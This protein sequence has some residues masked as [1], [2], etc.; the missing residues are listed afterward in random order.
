MKLNKPH[1]TDTQTE[2]ES[3]VADLLFDKDQVGKLKKNHSVSGTKHKIVGSNVLE[4]KKSIK[5]SQELVEINLKESLLSIDD[6]DKVTQLYDEQSARPDASQK[7]AESKSSAD[8]KNKDSISDIIQ[9]KRE[10]SAKGSEAGITESNSN[11]LSSRKTVEIDD[12]NHPLANSAESVEIDRLDKT[13]KELVTQESQKVAAKSAPLT[14]PK[15]PSMLDSESVSAD[16][17]S[18]SNSKSTQKEAK[19]AAT[20]TILE[21]E[22]AADERA[23]EIM[24]AS[25]EIPTQEPGDGPK[26]VPEVEVPNPIEG[27]REHRMQVEREA[28]SYEKREF[29]LEP[30]P[31][32]RL[33]GVEKL[34][35]KIAHVDLSAQPATQVADNRSTAPTTTKVSSKQATDVEQGKLEVVKNSFEHRDSGPLKHSLGS[36]FQTLVFEVN[37]LPLAVPLV[38]LGGIVNISEVEVTPLVGTPEWFVGLVPNERGNLMVVDTQRF[39]MPEKENTSDK[40]YDYLIVLDDTQWAL[41]CHSVGDA[42]NLTPDDIRWSARSSKRP[43]FAGMVVEYMSALIEVD[44]LI[45]MLAENVV[46]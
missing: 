25:R 30:E 6:T 9:L 43:W 42:K 3:Y 32:T 8:V 20:N 1:V 37:Q 2:L 45:N 23:A 15:D 17:G 21:Q 19:S 39:L 18:K 40:N 34:L 33:K 28:A 44:S 7:L 36:V 38:K 22:R 14:Q 35:S 26:D 31:D 5:S 4:S 16:E 29:K 11:V 10:Q 41:A 24:Q 12:T 46:E 13:A 27:E